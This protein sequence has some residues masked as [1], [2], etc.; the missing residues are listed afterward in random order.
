[1]PSPA[2]DQPA[3]VILSPFKPQVKNVT[4]E[5][6]ASSLYYVHLELPSAAD[7]LAA[8]HASRTDNAS[9]SSDDGASS[10]K[11]IPRKPLPDSARPLT[12]ES[13]PSGARPRPSTSASPRGSTV[14]AQALPLS[15]QSSVDG[16]RHAADAAESPAPALARARSAARPPST[17]MP[18][19]KPVA[20]RPTT[21]V[22]PPAEKAADSAALPPQ[23]VAPP[24]P[25]ERCLP[26]EPAPRN[27]LS[28]ARCAPPRSPSPKK[29]SRCNSA[30]GSP[31]T[32]TLIRRDPSSGHQWNVG[33]VS[34]RQLEPQPADAD[35]HGPQLLS[36]PPAAPMAPSAPIDIE[37][38]TSGYA[39]FR[40]MPP[41]RSAE[42][43]VEAMAAASDDSR[44]RPS[45]GVFS[46]QV[47][48][49]YS[50]SLATNIR[51]KLQRMEKA[52]RVRMNRGRSDSTAEA[53]PILVAPTSGSPPNEMQGMKPRGY[54]FLSPWD[55]RCEFR[56]CTAGRSVQCRHTLHDGD[57]A[58]YNPLMADQGGNSAPRSASLLV[59]ELRFNLPSSEIVGE[60]ARCARE[61]WR[62]HFDKLL[63]PADEPARDVDADD[64]AVSP[65][66]VNVG[67]ERAG[68]GNRGRRAKLG[69]LIVYDDGLKMLD[70]VVAANVGVWWGAW[71]RTF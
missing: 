26:P 64:D 4:A 13:L 16:P 61:Q 1:M 30:A 43:A 54:T 41:R 65:F 57:V 7:A 38:E 31:F 42:I 15:P 60:Q 35:H 33:R 51:E 29:R 58:V 44:R 8:P 47:T 34:S 27:S 36:L 3:D 12:P 59:S 40:R 10:P 2:N 68:G 24:P 49:G 69:K 20:S 52:S 53:A 37:I 71:E 45:I 18:L 9:R 11:T 70:L 19:R 67:S 39:K 17:T 50:K 6:V 66:E 28:A 14:A 48:M 22:P 55:G 46:R 56:T 62:G 25:R 63:R 23:P 5:D 21:G 32:L